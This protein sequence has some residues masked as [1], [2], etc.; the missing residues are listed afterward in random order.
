MQ[1]CFITSHANTWAT[2]K[3][4]VNSCILDVVKFQWT[5]CAVVC[6][7]FL[8]FFF[9]NTPLF[10]HAHPSSI[11]P[12]LLTLHV[13]AFRRSHSESELIMLLS[14]WM[15]WG[16]G[17]S[18]PPASARGVVLQLQTA[19]WRKWNEEAP[20]TDPKLR[21]GFSPSANQDWCDLRLSLQ[22]KNIFMEMFNSFSWKIAAGS[23]SCQ[24][25]VVSFLSLLLCS[26]LIS[27]WKPHGLLNCR[28]RY[29]HCMTPKKKAN[30]FLPS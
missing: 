21:M 24:L 26:L 19:R 13:P 17:G 16:G 9:S 10:R 25:R 20:E 12:P 5:D 8:L 23:L 11:R 22:C 6:L 4:I 15:E 2:S 7:F 29:C 14:L 30:P 27:C 1:L 18:F 3:N 28:F